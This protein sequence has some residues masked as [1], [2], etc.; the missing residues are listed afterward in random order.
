[1]KK[2]HFNVSNGEVV[3]PYSV[4]PPYY[5]LIS[6][7]MIKEIYMCFSVSNIANNGQ[8][9][10][11]E[12][13]EKELKIWEEYNSNLKKSLNK[14]VRSPKYWLKETNHTEQSYD[15]FIFIRFL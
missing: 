10:V 4:L 1:M 14:L 2:L 3:N 11:Q 13:V 9:W 8:N 6:K 15:R 5:T 7:G 12:Q